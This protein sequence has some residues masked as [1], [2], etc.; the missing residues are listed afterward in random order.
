MENDQTLNGV[1]LILTMN[2]I[3]GKSIND[4]IDQGL[5]FDIVESDDNR[6]ETLND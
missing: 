6:Q 2:D 3:E 5:I 4:L 1:P